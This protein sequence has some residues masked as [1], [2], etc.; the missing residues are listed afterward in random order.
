[1]REGLLYEK[2]YQDL[3]SRIELGDYGPGDRLPT[4]KELSGFYG[5]SRITMKKAMS[6]LVEKEIV[7]RKP[8]LGTFVN[9]TPDPA[10][11]RK[12]K[13]EKP[14]LKAQMT[15]ETGG[16]SAGVRGYVEGMGKKRIACIAEDV[17]DA[18]GTAALRAITGYANREGFDLILNLSLSS[19]E[20]EAQEIEFVKRA[21]AAG[22]IIVPV[23][24]NS[25]NKELLRA[26]VEDYPIVTIN[27]ELRGIPAS[28]V[29][30]DHGRAAYDLIRLFYE[31]GHRKIGILGDS[32]EEGTGLAERYRGFR[33]AAKRYGCQDEL[34]F[35]HEWK[36]SRREGGKVR[37]PLTKSPE[38]R[39]YYEKECSLLREFLET[40][41]GMKGF[42][43]CN[44]GRGHMMRRLAGELGLSIPK[45]I[46]LA[47]FDDMGYECGDI[48]LTHV[49]QPEDEIARTAVELLKKRMEN[50]RSEP[51]S[52]LVDYRIFDCGTVGEAE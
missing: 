1:M 3:L 7:V 25:Y 19:Q 45:D 39:S 33:A 41:P 42:V 38:D 48:S 50:N 8:G 2:V 13:A 11:I 5:V 4:E 49:H 17:S 40:N 22:L 10:E 21:G 29:R 9:R 47:C 32:P 35:F 24:G 36:E 6:I 20:L 37:P 26:V 30:I 34:I 44:F 51:E 16:G 31:K 14:A 15:E 28:S 52:I 18:F 46:S 23:M 12:E 27:R 43:G